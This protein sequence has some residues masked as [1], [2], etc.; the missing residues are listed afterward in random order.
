MTDKAWERFWEKDRE[1]ERAKKVN[2]QAEIEALE[3]NN[4]MMLREMERWEKTEK[5]RVARE[6]WEAE[7]AREGPLEDGRYH[8]AWA[9]FD[10][11]LGREGSGGQGEGARRAREEAQPEGARRAQGMLDARSRAQGMLDAKR[12]EREAQEE[13]DARRR[14][15]ARR[16]RE[17]AGGQG[18]GVGLAREEADARRRERDRRAREE[19]RAEPDPA[20]RKGK[21][22]RLTQ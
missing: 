7:R 14:E 11:E 8:E 6:A 1:E 13:L 9:A 18:E 22:P 2:E 20:R 12:R 16:A 21:Y 4:E 3:A 10:G 15:R 5:A 19:E 17:E